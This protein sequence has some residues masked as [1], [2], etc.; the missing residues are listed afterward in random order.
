MKVKA[1]EV[2]RYLGA[3]TTLASPPIKFGD[4]VKVSHIVG[5]KAFLVAHM[6]TSSDE[7]YYLFD[8]ELEATQSI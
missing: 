4:S 6:W 2:V 8:E 1:G 5:H 7:P 3:G